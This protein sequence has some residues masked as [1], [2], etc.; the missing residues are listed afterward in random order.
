MSDNSS[1]EKTVTIH[2]GDSTDENRQGGDGVDIMDL[3]SGEDTADAG[4]GYNVILGGSGDDNLTSDGNWDDVFGGSGDD[5]I[6]VT[7]RNAWVF[8]GTGN[9]TIYGGDEALSFDLL[10]GGDGNDTIHG[11]GGWDLIFG[12]EGDDTIDGGTGHDFI[13]GGA[14]DDD[15][16]G[17]SG[18]DTFYFREGHG[19]DTIQDFNAAEGDRIDLVGFDDTITWAQLS[20]RITTVVDEN[21]AVTGVQIDLSDWGGGTLILNGITDVND[22]TE[23]MFVL[24]VIQGDDDS[25]D[26]LVGGASDDTMSGGTGAD[27]FR[28]YEGSG[29]DTITDFSTTDGDK[30]DLTWFDASI[31]WAQLQAAMTSVE[32]DE[33][34]TDVDETATIIDLSAWGGGT[35][36]L[37]GVSATDLTED[38]FLLHDLHGEDGVGNYIVGGIGDD[39]MSGGTGADVFYFYEGHGDDTI[40]D[41]SATEGDIIDLNWFSQAI[42]WEEL[43]ANITQVEDDAGTR[44]VDETAT[45]IDLST[46]GGGSIT[47]QGVTA[48]D[49][50]ADMFNLP[51]GTAGYYIYGGSG[52]DALEGTRGHDNIFGQE[53]DDAI[54]GGIGHD[55]L[56]GGE[57]AD[58]LGGG[59]GNDLLIGGEGNDTLDGGEGN[60]WSVGGEG[61]DTFVF[62]SGHG[63]D[64]IADF[65]DGEDLIDLSAFTGIAGYGDLTVTQNGNDVVIDLSG[66]AG[67][68]TITLL[69]FTL[70]DLDENDFA[71]Y[72][73]PP[74]GG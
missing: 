27:T 70:A 15:L 6:T 61:A 50:T 49:L 68:G 26:I 17:G 54:S 40:T 46:W 53:G 5:T 65:A 11:R 39:T 10:S 25:D 34:T 69:D 60:D 18:V 32:D 24:N 51:D 3:G 71:F 14:G 13:V 12:G 4:R 2:L 44:D 73:A 37:N 64:T 63:S 59:E 43:S 9:D 52:D 47:L 33:Q 55:W 16:T 30:I 23:D 67:G 42:T 57:G 35:I 8:G 72:E 56:F 74:D 21:N 66:Q 1:E 38:M 45:V 41:F 62:A 20:S 36:T 29:N 58:T 19:T 28:F 7:G 31:T 22:V 48:T